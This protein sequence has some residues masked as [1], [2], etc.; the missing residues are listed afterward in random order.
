M[1]RLLRR[2]SPGRGVVARRFSAFSAKVPLADPDPILSLNDAVRKVARGRSCLRPPLRC[3]S[4]DLTL[5]CCR[6]A[7]LSPGDTMSRILQRI[8]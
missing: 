5:L 4:A 6:V 1:L 8:R 2:I 7:G 3:L